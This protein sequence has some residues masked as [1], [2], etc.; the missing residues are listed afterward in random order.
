ME[1]HKKCCFIGHR[2]V[3]LTDEEKRKI[4]NALINIIEDGV[5]IFLFGSRS[6]FDDL[7]HDL[8]TGLQGVY[9]QIKRVYVRAE[10]PDISDVYESYLRKSYE[11]TYFPPEIRGAGRAVYVERNFGM[12]DKSDYCVF[13]YDAQNART[14]SG[15]KKAYEYAQ[16]KG[17]SVI[18]I[19][20]IN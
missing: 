16:K 12:I 15:T 6:R 10:Y 20:E 3:C 19:F 11:H 8:V 14:K 9:P 18:N 2:H 5:D 13:Y 4:N 1:K 7:C 17:K